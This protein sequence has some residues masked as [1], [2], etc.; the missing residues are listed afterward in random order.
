M[1]RPET[2][3]LMEKYLLFC[4]ENPF[5][6][7][8]EQLEKVESDIISPRDGIVS[9]AYV[10]FTLWMRGLKSRQEYFAEKI[11]KVLPQAKYQ[12]LLEVGCGRTAGLSKLLAAKGYEMTAMDPQLIPE[13][14]EKYQEY[15]IN[16][17]KD[18]FIFGKTDITA[19]DAV[20]AQEPCD[21]AEHIIRECIVRRKDFVVSL[22][23]VAHR[24]MNG[25]MPKDVYAWYDYLEKLGGD[26]C[27]LIRSRMV[28][29]YV[30]H[31]MV[32]IFS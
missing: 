3:I 26:D 8:D 9:D 24:L 6:F 2:A 12:K 19:F 20:V 30:S 1:A 4:K 18:A 5:G 15:H 32:G 25:E 10:D 11:E 13:S 27:I 28:P 17:V 14:V 23:G 29:G 22:C 31:V 7:V 21:A 16:C